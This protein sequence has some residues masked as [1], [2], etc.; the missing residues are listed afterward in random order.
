MSCAL[1]AVVITAFHSILIN[2]CVFYMLLLIRLSLFISVKNYK[3]L[4]ID[5]LCIIL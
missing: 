3:N 5:I 4:M 1:N 2:F